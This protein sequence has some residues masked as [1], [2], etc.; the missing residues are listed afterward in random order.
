[1]PHD[2]AGHHS[3]DPTYLARFP[4]PD[5]LFAMVMLGM[6]GRVD[7]ICHSRP[8]AAWYVSENIWNE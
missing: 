1:M 3:W 8:Q 5:V 7:R 6:R 2:P 4:Q